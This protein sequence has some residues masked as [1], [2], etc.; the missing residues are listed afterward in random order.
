MENPI[1]NLFLTEIV[2][3]TS[4]VLIKMTED[5]IKIIKFSG[6]QEDYTYWAEKFLARASIKGYDEILEGTVEVA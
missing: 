5:S 2:F 6:K 4:Q 1:I 3:L